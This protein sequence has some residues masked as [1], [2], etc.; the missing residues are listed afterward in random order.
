MR[1][2]MHFALGAALVTGTLGP[3]V[4]YR[5]PAKSAANTSTT[6]SD[7]AAKAATVLEVQNT[8]FNDAV[9]YAVQGV[10]VVRLGDVTGLTTRNLTLPKDLVFGTSSMRFAVRTIGKRGRQVSDEI[11]VSQ[12]DTVS[13]FI[14]PF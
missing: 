7:S 3:P 13:L 11:S 14:P 5:L 4:A 9:I 2:M 10:R 6:A 8:A 12:G 1:S